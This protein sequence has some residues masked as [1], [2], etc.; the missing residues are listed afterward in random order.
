MSLA[1]E[2]EKEAVMEDA[3]SGS[4]GLRHTRKFAKAGRSYSPSYGVKKGLIRDPHW[5]APLTDGEGA[6]PRRQ[7]LR[8]PTTFEVHSSSSKFTVQGDLSVGGAMFVAPNRIED[9]YVVIVPEKDHT[10]RARG[11]IIGRRTEA[12]G[13]VHHVRFDDEPETA[14][15][16]RLVAKL[17]E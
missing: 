7:S 12:N 13:V 16:E 17:A 9:E 5:P 10:I 6:S 8:V 11:K 2:H 4:G 14:Q 3:F 15:I 1:S